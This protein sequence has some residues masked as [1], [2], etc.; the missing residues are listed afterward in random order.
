MLKRSLTALAAIAF[1]A[2][3]AF[4]APQNFQD[5]MNNL[6]AT[7][8]MRGKDVLAAPYP[9]RWYTFF[10]DFTKEYT[11]ADW[12]L[13]T[14]EAGS[15]SATEVITDEDKGIL[16]I[17]N[18]NADDDR[19]FYQTKQEGWTFTAGK[20]LYFEARFKTLEVIQEDF[21]MGLQVRDTTPLAVS[22]GIFFQK[23][24][25]D[26]IL[27]FH[28]CIASVCSDSTGVKTLTADT[29]YTMSFYYDGVSTVQVAVDNVILGTYTIATPP[30]T[31]LTI[32]FGVQQGEVTNVKT[33]SVDYIYVAKER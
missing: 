8:W 33:M 17:T 31:E 19:D 20:K 30:T 4:A 12:T 27:D 14:T 9:A 25:G 18:D 28:S 2:G 22:D 1:A 21:V 23:D 7:H 3:V 13:T 6:P 5:G 16:L 10:E 11:E 29:Y 15:G 26:A 32:S 24:D